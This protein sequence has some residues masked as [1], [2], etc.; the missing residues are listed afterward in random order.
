[1]ARV[2]PAQASRPTINA[3]PSIVVVRVKEL[4]VHQLLL[5]MAVLV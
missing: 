1:M 2:G 4:A 5:A 3:V